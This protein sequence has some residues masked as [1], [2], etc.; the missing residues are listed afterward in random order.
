MVASRKF[1]DSGVFIFAMMAAGGDLGASVVPQLVGI[2]TDGVMANPSA[3]TLAAK[4]SLT[5]EQLG[6]RAGMLCG[7]LFPLIAIFIYLH[8]WRKHTKSQ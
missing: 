6:M 3:A 5:T 1:P 4:L 8:I 7:M 2:V